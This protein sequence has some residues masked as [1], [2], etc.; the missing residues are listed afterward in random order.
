V[1]LEYQFTDDSYAIGVGIVHRFGKPSR[2]SARAAFE[3]DN[4]WPTS[5]NPN[6]PKKYASKERLKTDA[7]GEPVRDKDGNFV[8]VPVYEDEQGK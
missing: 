5:L 2:P 8:F 1:S 6:P 3:E 4:S 7:S